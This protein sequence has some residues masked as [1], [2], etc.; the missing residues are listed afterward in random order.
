MLAGCTRR[1]PVA[2]IYCTQAVDRNIA[3]REQDIHTLTLR[4]AREVS[5]Y[6]A[7]YPGTPHRNIFRLTFSTNYFS[8]VTTSISSPSA[9]STNVSP[10]SS[11]FEAWHSS[12]SASVLALVEPRPLPTPTSQLDCFDLKV[13]KHHRRWTVRPSSGHPPILVIL[14]DVV[15]K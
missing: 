14:N 5:V 15:R 2:G 12:H 4:S 9:S 11:S 8:T 1:I 13:R 7:G 6:W 3:I 10:R